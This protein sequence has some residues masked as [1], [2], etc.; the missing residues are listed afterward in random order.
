MRVYPTCLVLVLLPLCHSLGGQSGLQLPE[1]PQ[2]HKAWHADAGIPTNILSAVETLFKQGFPD[3]RGCEYR[4]IEVEVSGMWNSKSSLVKTRGW[5]LPAKSRESNRFAICWNGLIYPV[6]K[7]SAPADLHSEITD[8]FRPVTLTLTNSV[9][10][11][12]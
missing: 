8:Q 11:T 3:P 4:E 5:V 10:G 9:N 12:N 2:Q 6:T 1:P 7:I